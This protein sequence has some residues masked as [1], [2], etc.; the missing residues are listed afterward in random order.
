M[1]PTFYGL[2]IG[3]S[4]LYVSQKGLDVTGHN[5]AN[6]ETAGYSRQVLNNTAYDPMGYMQKFRP[7]DM[8]LV[9]AGSYVKI[10]SQIRDKFLDR[11]YRT[12]DNLNA[13]WASRTQGLSYIEALFESADV[14][15]LKTNIDN[16]FSAFTTYEEEDPTKKGLREVVI[17]NAKTL[18]ENF[19]QMYTRLESLQES[20]NISV[21]AM[22][23]KINNITS[24]IAALN[25]Q[26]YRYEILTENQPANDLR[27]KRNLLLDELSEI[28]NINY[29]E[30]P[31]GKFRVWVGGT[32]NNFVDCYERDANG[33]ALS[34]L[35]IIPKPENGI[36]VVDHIYQSSFTVNEVDM[37]PPDYDASGVNMR[38]KWQ[39]ALDP[40]TRIDVTDPLAVPKPNYLLYG[41][42]SA[43]GKTYRPGITVDANGTPNGFSTTIPPG[44]TPDVLDIDGDGRSDFV[45][46]SLPVDNLI[47]HIYLNFYSSQDDDVTEPPSLATSI[48]GQTYG[49]LT[50]GELKAHLDLRDNNGTSGVAEG[51]LGIPHFMDRLNK[52]ARSLVQNFNEIH[53]QGYTHPGG[54]DSHTFQNFFY[55]EMEAYQDFNETQTLVAGGYS[56][57]SNGLR[58]NDSVAPPTIVDA[59]G[60]VVYTT[61]GTDILDSAGT[62]VGTY[63]LT[64][65]DVTLNITAPTGIDTDGDGQ[66]SAT[67]RTAAFDA[68]GDGTLSA[69]ERAAEQAFYVASIVDADNNGIADTIDNI[70]AKN[71]R[72]DDAIADLASGA[73]RVALSSLKIGLMPD[74]TTIDN[75]QEGNNEIARA[76]YELSN[77]KLIELGFN[78]ATSVKIGSFVGFENETELTIALTLN[79][80]KVRGKNQASQTLAVSN[81]R[82]SIMG[83]SMDEEMTNL[84]RYQ[85]AYSGNSRVITTM[86]DILDTLIN[87]TGRVGL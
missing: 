77:N 73:F 79:Q 87:R 50:G 71:I 11:Q 83:V 72:L 2:S 17:S 63:T 3:V 59:N 85:H 55:Q 16:L 38:K 56:D 39:L 86:D 51:K 22:S 42:F 5:I 9:G 8:A 1:R 82:T 20:E 57:F 69:A 40:T 4:G 37:S 60:T 46:T 36:L 18:L 15:S 76:L 28:V 13:E 80:S 45:D 62:T 27:D 12:E 19:H 30:G 6:T 47:D 84:I 78:T 54:G 35:V 33:T 64:A 65:T 23:I 43:D 53:R 44:T 61:N 14:S 10:L 21:Q 26:I 52:L 75:T 25:K 34:P 74:G 7:V 24:N 32:A 31:D 58:F 81:Q 68:D 48:P 66:I 70:T 49:A 41:V 29:D 67:E